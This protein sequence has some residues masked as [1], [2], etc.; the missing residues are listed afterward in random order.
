MAT[1][2]KSAAAKRAAAEASNVP[3]KVKFLGATYAGPPT[4][5]GTVVFDIA[6]FED[7]GD[8]GALRRIIVDLFGEDG[9]SAIREQVADEGIQFTDAAE[10]L[11]ELIAAIFEAYGLDQ[12][13]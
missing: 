4:L 1:V 8:L 12:G 13:E 7:S 3:V 2:N 6:D 10:K 5:P 9:W 11:G